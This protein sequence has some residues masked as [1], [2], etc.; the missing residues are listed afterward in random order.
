MFTNKNKSLMLYEVEESQYKYLYQIP[1]K[2]NRYI[3]LKTETTGLDIENDKA[4]KLSAVEIFNGELTGDSR[5]VFLNE[6]EDEDKEKSKSNK[7]NIRKNLMDFVDFLGGCV[8]FS[9]N[10]IFH[11]RVLNKVLMSYGFQSIEKTQFRCSLRIFRILINEIAPYIDKRYLGLIQCC[12]I[13]H[14]NMNENNMGNDSVLVGRL[15]QKFY[16]ILDKN[17]F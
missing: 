12:Q 10:S 6:D 7:K 4:I 14:I 9:H 2:K 3:C 13:L 8:I 1:P 5:V 17:P 15:V 11:S 16:E